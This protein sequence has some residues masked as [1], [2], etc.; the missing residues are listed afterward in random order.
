MASASQSLRWRVGNVVGTATC[1]LLLTSQRSIMTV[2]GFLGPLDTCTLGVLKASR[3][4]GGVMAAILFS[5][6]KFIESRGSLP[7]NALRTAAIGDN[8]IFL[9]RQYKCHTCS[10]ASASLTRA[11]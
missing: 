8:S 5:Y 3:A 4:V 6:G 2:I 11:A 7:L 10:V 1:L 9:V